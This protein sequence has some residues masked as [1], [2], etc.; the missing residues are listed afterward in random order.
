MPLRLPLIAFALTLIPLA[1]A[2]I[3]PVPVSLRSTVHQQIGKTNVAVEYSRPS[4]KGRPIFG[5]LVPY[6]EVWRTGAN[7]ST[8]LDF[9][10]PLTIGDTELPAGRY[11]LFTIPGEKSWTIIIN[12]VP[13]EFGA[14]TYKPEKDV[15]RFEA[16]PIHSETYIETFEIAFANLGQNS[17]ELQLRWANTTVPVPLA[18]TEASNHQVMLSHIKA[19]IIDGGDPTWANYGEAARYYDKHDLDL[20]AADQWYAKCAELNPDAFWMYVERAK[21]L[22]RLDRQSDAR[23]TL[24]GGL[25]A[26]QRIKNQG[27]IDWIKGELAN[28][29]EN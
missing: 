25:K 8:S 28:L 24:E 1:S 29:P 18:V 7:V 15:L 2:T 16:T 13:D 12:A 10:T 27:G 23:S 22:L 9:D 14:F 6:G 11:A 20:E 5:D 4:A 17:A 26:A 19:D 21:L 3:L